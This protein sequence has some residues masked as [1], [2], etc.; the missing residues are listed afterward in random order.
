MKLTRLTLQVTL[1]GSLAEH[2]KANTD[3]LCSTVERAFR[4]ALFSCTGVSVSIQFE[5]EDRYGNPIARSE[6]PTGE[7]DNE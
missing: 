6:A 7:D 2:V 4:K 1:P 3:R 5:G